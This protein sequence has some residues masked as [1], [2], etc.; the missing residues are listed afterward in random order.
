MQSSLGVV[1]FEKYRVKCIIGVEPHE[2]AHAQDLLIDLKVEVNLSAVAVS[3][4]LSDTIDY[5]QLAAVC[6][7]MAQEG[8]YLLLEKYAA[9][10]S[11]A[12]LE[13]FPVQSVTICVRKPHPFEGVEC[14]LVELRVNRAEMRGEL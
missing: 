13:Q 2:R 10:L 12:I 1:G 5:V 9:D 7:R 3:G 8:A 11:Q 6:A 4:L 14:A